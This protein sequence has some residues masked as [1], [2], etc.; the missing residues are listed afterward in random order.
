VDAV[1]AIQAT[2]WPLAGQSMRGLWL[3]IDPQTDG[4]WWQLSDD[5]VWLNAVAGKKILN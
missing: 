5:F 3:Y 1:R 4:N 2:A